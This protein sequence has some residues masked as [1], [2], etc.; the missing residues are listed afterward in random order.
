MSQKTD[1][2]SELV[3]LSKLNGEFH[4]NYGRLLGAY[5]YIRPIS[6]A[7]PPTILLARLDV[8]GLFGLCRLA[9]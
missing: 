9:C 8:V 2:S 7:R 4:K 5:L 1:R 3:E 6:A